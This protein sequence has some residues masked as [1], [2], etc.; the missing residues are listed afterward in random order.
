M[1]HVHDWFLGN[2]DEWCSCGVY[3][4]GSHYGIPQGVI[5]SVPCKCLGN[6]Q[7][8]IVKVNVIRSYFI[9]FKL[10]MLQMLRDCFLH[11][12]QIILL[13]DLPIDDFSKGKMKITADELVEERQMALAAI[14]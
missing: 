4:D 3:S 9:K 11:R 13:Q 5:Y 7:I 6:G 2:K 1:D 10:K 14:Q 12:E 8:E